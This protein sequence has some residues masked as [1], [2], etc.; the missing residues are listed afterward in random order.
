MSVRLTVG[1]KLNQDPANRYT[2]I[3]FLLHF[4]RFKIIF[5]GDGAFLFEKIPHP[6]IKNQMWWI[7]LGRS[8]VATCLK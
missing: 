6:P 3:Y 7:D 1:I 5:F 8:R 4:P 2:V